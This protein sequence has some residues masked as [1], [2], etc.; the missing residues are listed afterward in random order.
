M[1][2]SVTVLHVDDEEFAALTGTYL[3]SAEEALDVTTVHSPEVALDRL[4]A[5]AVDCV[6]TDFDMGAA[7]GIELLADV[8]ERAPDLPCIL[9]TARNDEALI[10]R[11]LETGATEYLQKGRLAQFT[12]LAHRIQTTV[13]VHSETETAKRSSADGGTATVE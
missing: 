8:R 5:D 6:V 3:E 1:R 12:P 2:E 13:S 7:D 10:E 9:F 11:A 4:V